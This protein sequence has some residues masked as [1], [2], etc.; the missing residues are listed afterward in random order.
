VIWG[1]ESGKI[2]QSILWLSI[3]RWSKGAFA[4]R[5]HTSLAIYFFDGIGNYEAPFACIWSL[6]AGRDEVNAPRHTRMSYPSVDCCGT[7]SLLKHR[8]PNSSTPCVT[9]RVN[10]CFQG[11]SGSSPPK[12]LHWMPLTYMDYLA[13]DTQSEH[14]QY[15][16]LPNPSCPL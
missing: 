13:E 10:I 3:S 15:G 8:L 4:T 11:L 7:K 6:Q 9:L 2:A 1:V 16:L 5:S 14:V 12:V